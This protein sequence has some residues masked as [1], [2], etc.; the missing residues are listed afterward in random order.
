MKIKKIVAVPVMVVALTSLCVISPGTSPA[1][2]AN[3]RGSLMVDDIHFDSLDSLLTATPTPEPTPTPTPEPTP[4]LE[5]SPEVV[6]DPVPV[7]D[8]YAP[9]PVPAPAPVYTP[10]PQDTYVEPIPAPAYVAPAPNT[11]SIYTTGCND[12]NNLQ[13]CVDAGGISAIDLSPWGTPFLFAGH[14]GGPAGQFLNF[15]PGDIVNVSGVGAGTYVV[16]YDA[17][18]PHKVNNVSALSGGYAF[19]VC[20]GFSSIRIVYADKVA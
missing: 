8:S 12:L 19:Q 16:T 11:Y 10:E 1:A 2:G 15:Q 5:T 7:E 6:P 18:L 3:G 9:V 17:W 20:L 4:T 13:G 14:D